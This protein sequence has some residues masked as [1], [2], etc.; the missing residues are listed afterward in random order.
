[1]HGSIRLTGVVVATLMVAGLVAA[2]VPRE[3]AP[4]GH[5]LYQ[6][7][8]AICHGA[9]GTGDGPAA[10]G[11]A[12]PLPDLTTLTA[13]NGGVFPLREVMAQ[14]DGYGRGARLQADA[15]PEMGHLLEGPIERVDTG[16]GI[17]TPTP[18]KLVALARY[19]ESL[20]Q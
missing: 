6:D 2:C 17:M 18:V 8:C 11:R 9:T 1:M 5:A 7:N 13:R 4:S 12:Q 20:Q 10:A 16:D 19:L 3:Y 14:I 15:M